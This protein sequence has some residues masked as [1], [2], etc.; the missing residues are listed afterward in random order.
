MKI[1]NYAVPVMHEFQ[2]LN[3]GEAFISHKDAYK[4][5][6]FMR[7]PDS[8]LHDANEPYE[9]FNAVCLNDGD[10]YY[11]GPTDLVEVVEV[12]LVVKPKINK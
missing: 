12:S 8:T 3:E 9:D 6:V 10:V 4:Y 2:Y 5:Q 11:F 7:V 1:E